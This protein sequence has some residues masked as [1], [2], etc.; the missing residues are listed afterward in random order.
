MRKI[1]FLLLALTMLT[2]S[3][4][5]H[6]PVSNGVT[7]AM[8][9]DTLYYYM[10][11]YYYWYNYIPAISK[12]DYADPYTLLK[13]MTYKTLDRWSFVADY[14]AFNA[15]M[16]GTFVG[17]GISIGLD[18]N[19]VARIAMIYNKAPLYASGVRRG[20]IVKKVNN[21]EVAPIFISGDAAAYNTMF[22]PSTAGVTNTFLFQKPSGVDTTISSTKASFTVN[23]VLVYDTLKL[24][25]GVTGHLVFDAFIE[26]SEAE[27]GTAFT[28]FKAQNITNLIVDLRYNTGGYLYIAQELASYIAGNSV[29]GSVFVKLTF[30]DKLTSYNQAFPFL[31]ASTTIGLSKVVFITTRSTASASEAVM[32]G[33]VSH[34]ISV[35]SVGDTTNGKPVGMSGYA[36][37]EKYWFWPITFKLVNSADH[38]EY[39]DGIAPD[40]LA[41]DDLKYDFS[42]RREA[43]LKQAISYLE[44]G[45]FTTKGAETF[46]RTRTMGEKPAWMSNA[47]VIDK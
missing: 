28:Y 6:E 47:F 40:K 39:F 18:E 37:G 41:M 15:E 46:K 35:I 11:D 22:G 13:A 43:S 31:S 19:N 10:K 3:C 8:A 16:Q 26:P 20:W 5:K 42:D 34:N 32:N 12:E 17:H 21:T 29:A 30:N 38:G 24:K 25:T 23:S 9:R 45:S 27:L 14:D 2:A 1:I 33:L 4:K 36:C 7:A 44:T